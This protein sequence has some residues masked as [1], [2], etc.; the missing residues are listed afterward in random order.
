MSVNDELGAANWYKSTKSAG[1]KDCVEVAHLG[2]GRVGVRDSKN[3][4]GPALIFT[5]SEWDS[6]LTRTR[7][8]HIDHH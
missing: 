4:S 3:P 1:G 2:Q 6:F 8:G 7:A 5:P